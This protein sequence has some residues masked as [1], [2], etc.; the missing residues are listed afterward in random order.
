PVGHACTAV[1]IASRGSPA[2]STTTALVSSS[3]SNVPG[4]YTMHMPLPMQRS[5]STVTDHFGVASGIG[6][7]R[8]LGRREAVEALG[9][10]AE[11][12]V[13]RLLGEVPDAVLHDLDRI[14][15]GGVRVRVVGLA[16]DVVLADLVEATDAVRVVDA[17]AEDVVAERGSDVEVVEVEL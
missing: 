16:H 8:R 11:Q 4:A 1:R 2:G 12:L 5:R 15:P 6:Q 10:A 7:H 14:R 9:V 13:L 3:C 17:A